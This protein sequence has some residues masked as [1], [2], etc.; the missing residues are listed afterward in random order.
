M[1]EVL[2]A[3]ISEKSDVVAGHECQ[4]L[5][6]HVRSELVV[7]YLERPGCNLQR[8]IRMQKTFVLIHRAT[9]GQVGIFAH[10]SPGLRDRC[11]LRCTVNNGHACLK[12]PAAVR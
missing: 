5:L 1:I 2:F 10:S 12:P 4:G 8:G 6:K 7:W 9:E 3:S 11:S